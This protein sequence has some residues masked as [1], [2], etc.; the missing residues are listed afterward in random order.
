MVKLRENFPDLAL[1]QA[2]VRQGASCS[3]LGPRALEDCLLSRLLL[4]LLARPS[5][6]SRRRQCGNCVVGC[7]PFIFHVPSRSPCLRAGLDIPPS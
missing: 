3:S 5:L 6:H 7:F 1:E 2:G 4:P